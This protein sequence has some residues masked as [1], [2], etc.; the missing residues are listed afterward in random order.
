M[1]VIAEAVKVLP[2]PTVCAEVV[3]VVVDVLVSK[4]GPS[5]KSTVC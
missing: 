2:V 1:P 4:Y 3:I 5:T